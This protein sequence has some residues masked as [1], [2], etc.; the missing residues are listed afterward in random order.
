MNEKRLV[1][2]IKEE[3]RISQEF[4]NQNRADIKKIELNIKYYEGQ[5]DALN[6]ALNTISK[7]EGE[8]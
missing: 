6:M 7:Q 1:D 5:V 4:I 8:K 2:N 3:I